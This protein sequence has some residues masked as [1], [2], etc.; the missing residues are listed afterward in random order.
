M[1]AS[2]KHHK[3]TTVAPVVVPLCI[4]GASTMLSWRHYGASVVVHRGILGASMVPPWC[5][6]RGLVLPS[7]CFRGMSR[8]FLDGASVVSCLL[9]TAI[10]PWYLHNAFVGPP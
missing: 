8:R 1:K 5:S 6:H 3:G 7:W 2:Q 4:R 10:V 9:G